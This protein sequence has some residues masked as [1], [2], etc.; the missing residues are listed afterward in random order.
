MNITVYGGALEVG[1]SCIVVETRDVRIALDYGVRVGEAVR[2]DFPT[3]LDAVV[4]SH[5]HLDHT[6]SLLNLSPT[7]VPIISTP[8]TRDIS[9]L[10]LIDMIR[11]HEK[12]GEFIPYDVVDVDLLLNHWHI[13]KPYNGIS[14]PGMEIQLIPA[15]HVLGAVMILLKIGNRKILYTGDFC[16]HDSEILNGLKLE[17][18]PKNIDLL[19]CESTYGA[20]VRPPREELLDE[21]Y[22]T[23]KR[24]I[25]R[26]GNL[27]LPSFAFHR[28]QENII[29]IDRGMLE[30]VIPYY[31]GYF[32][33]KLARE[34]SRAFNHYKYYF[35]DWIRRERKP[36]KARNIYYA[37]SLKHVKEPAI[38]VATAGFGHVGVS[39]KLLYEWGTQPENAV[40]IT[41]GYIPED[42]PLYSA[43][44]KG[45]VP[46]NGGR[47]QISA[48]VKQIELS[49]HPDQTELIEFI[50]QIN[51]KQTLLVH[52][53]EENA[54]TLAKLIEDKTNVI[55]P[56][57]METFKLAA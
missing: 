50:S 32:M 41:T 29:R 16:L 44:H 43:L 54:G 25:E 47:I 8:P 6:G 14:L 10:L 27:L 20:K 9:E 36:F 55:I 49:G 31:R 51:P 15:G 38:I 22:S 37:K 30:G 45:Y 11:V 18:I 35:K 17:D 21:F 57:P 23:I 4:I 19:I 33:S 26:D 46:E 12:R 39:R 48:E 13:L 3:N 1:A 24:V 40:I 53:D 42:S 56:K 5:A 52:G 34:I 28:T 7:S 2:T